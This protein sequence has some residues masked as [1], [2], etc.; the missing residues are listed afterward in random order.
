[1][2]RTER[3][4]PVDLGV[5][6]EPNV[7][8]PWL[9]HHLSTAAL[10][11]NPHFDDPNPSP[12]VLVWRY[13][14]GAVLEPV[15]DDTIWGHRL[16]NAGLKDCLWAGEVINSSWIG[17]FDLPGRSR[18][19]PRSGAWTIKRHFVLRLKE[20]TFEVIAESF[21]VARPESDSF[22]FAAQSVLTHRI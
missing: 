10:V 11:L 6:W 21:E 22:A 3:V 14:W 18:R 8:D 15:D 19:R 4:I 7:Q 9:V 5:V 1:M 13:C 12:L 16:W 17:T 20:A 2:A